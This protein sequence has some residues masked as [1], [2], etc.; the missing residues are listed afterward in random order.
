ME[1]LAF[2][3]IITSAINASNGAST[4]ATITAQSGSIT[5]SVG[6]TLIIA[7]L[8]TGGGA[9]AISINGG[10]TITDSVAVGSNFGSSAAY[11]VLSAASAQN[12]TWNVTTTST[13]LTAAIAAFAY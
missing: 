13:Q 6:N 3:G 1:V 7:G 12:P 8:G 9:G 2:S 11:L 5:P 4:N 10:Y